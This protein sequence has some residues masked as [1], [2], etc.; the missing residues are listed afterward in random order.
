MLLIFGCSAA[1]WMRRLNR[2]LQLFPSIYIVP[3]MQV[4]KHGLSLGGLGLGD[5]DA[6]AD[7][8]QGLQR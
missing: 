7:C 5:A 1:F 2:G 6:G 8:S 4:R 3:M